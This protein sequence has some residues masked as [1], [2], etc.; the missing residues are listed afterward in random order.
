MHAAGTSF[1]TYLYRGEWVR[2]CVCVRIPR[3]RACACTGRVERSQMNKEKEAED[4]DMAL[5]QEMTT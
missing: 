3:V 5:G 1:G 4:N 2:V